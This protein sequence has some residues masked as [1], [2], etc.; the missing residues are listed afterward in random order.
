MLVCVCAVS[1]AGTYT[2]T[3]LS[4]ETYFETA[5]SRVFSVAIQG[6]TMAPALDMVALS[7]VRT[8]VNV[9]R[10]MALTTSVTITL[11]G[12]TQNPR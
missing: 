2:V 8:A 6:V 3:V 9:S 5:G 10:T 11:T 1:D 4:A 12:I 7:G